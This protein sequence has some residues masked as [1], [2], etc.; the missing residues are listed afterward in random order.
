MKNLPAVGTRQTLQDGG[1]QVDVLAHGNFEGVEVAICQDGTKPIICTADA[2][3][4]EA[5]DYKGHANLAEM[6]K[7][8]LALWRD[9]IEALKDCTPCDYENELQALDDI[10]AAVKAELA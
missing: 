5:P 7:G 4:A 8:Q 6:I 1:R 2:F 10:E 3:K 9:G